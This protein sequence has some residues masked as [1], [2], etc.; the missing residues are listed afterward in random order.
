MELFS[1]AYAVPATPLL[2]IFPGLITAPKTIGRWN[3]SRRCNA[4][5]PG[6]SVWKPSNKLSHW[7]PRELSFAGWLVRL[8]RALSVP[9]LLASDLINGCS[10]NQRSSRHD[11]CFCFRFVLVSSLYVSS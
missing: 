10:R 1:A 3:V 5:K 6:R 4:D 11:Q 7:V 8:Q 2:S 9:C